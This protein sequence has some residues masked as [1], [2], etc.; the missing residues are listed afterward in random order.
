MTAS[1]FLYIIK[2][3]SK[4]YTQGEIIMKLKK[5]TITDK[6]KSYA[7][8]KG[9]KLQDGSYIAF[10]NTSR[11]IYSGIT[12]RPVKE[13]IDEYG[14]IIRE[15]KDILYG[16]LLDFANGNVLLDSASG[17]P[18]KPNA[19]NLNKAFPNPLLMTKMESRAGQMLGH[20]A[21]MLG[22]VNSEE[23]NSGRGLYRAVMNPYAE[24]FYKDFIIDSEGKLKDGDMSGADMFKNSSWYARLKVGRQEWGQ[25]LLLFSEYALRGEIKY[26]ALPEVY[27][28]KELPQLNQQL[29][30]AHKKGNLRKDLGLGKGAY[31]ALRHMNIGGI[32]NIISDRNNI[33]ENWQETLKRQKFDK[34][35]TLAIDKL[36]QSNMTI[37]ID[38]ESLTNILRNN[39]NDVKDIINYIET[40]GKEVNIYKLVEYLAVDIFTHQAVPL[41]RALNLLKDYYQMVYMYPNFVKYPKYLTVAHDIAQRNYRQQNNANLDSEISKHYEKHTEEEGMFTYGGHRFAVLALRSAKEI[42]GEGTAQSNCVGSYSTSVASGHSFIFSLRRLDTPSKSWIT[43]EVDENNWIVQSYQTYNQSISG[44]ATEYLSAWANRVGLEF[45][46]HVTGMAINNGT[47]M[48]AKARKVD[49]SIE[50]LHVSP[51]TALAVPDDEVSQYIAR[52]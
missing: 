30:Q 48:A 9:E 19:N 28:I 51:K 20:F 5:E 6:M 7:I 43:V 23:Y 35:M 26:R 16:F 11:G 27:D 46:S 8:A 15:D 24:T 13:I 31:N 10:F 21:H 22:A 33:T 17:N 49:E 36:Y 25:L 44:Q 47:V 32:Y 42:I 1:G 18:I 38:R 12:Y 4:K 14:M 39:Y 52:L 3:L 41:Y 50:D 45:A 40:A 34:Q 37:L 2:T 29:Y